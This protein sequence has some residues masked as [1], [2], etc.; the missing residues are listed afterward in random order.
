MRRLEDLS[1]VQGG[2]EHRVPLANVNVTAANLTEQEKR[3]NMLTRLVQLGFEPAESLAAVG[4]EQIT[5]TGLPTVQLQAASQFDALDPSAAYPVRD[6]DP[7]E[8]AE[9]IGA[10]IRNMP[11]P[12]INVQVPEQPARSKRVERDAHGNITGI[13]EE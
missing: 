10:Q 4:L 9:A 7:A 8:F 11:Q 5:H 6:L 2:D 1:P 3:V 13:V 12:V